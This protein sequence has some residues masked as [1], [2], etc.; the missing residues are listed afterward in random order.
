MATAKKLGFKKGDFI[1]TECNFPGILISDVHTS[2]PVAEVWG[3]EHE[4]GSVYADK[5]QRINRD[6]FMAI[7]RNRGYLNL[8]PFSDISREALREASKDIR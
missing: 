5:I 6:E 8:A 1:L 7:T 3:L 4:G 2:T